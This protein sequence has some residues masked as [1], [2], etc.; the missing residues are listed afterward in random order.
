MTREVHLRMHMRLL[1]KLRRF[2]ATVTAVL[3]GTGALGAAAAV[4]ST[5]ALAAAGCSA[6]YSEPSVWNTGFTASFNV[7]NTG[8][9]AITGWT[10]V[11]TYGSGNPTIQPTGWN[12]T[13]SQTGNTVTITNMSYN[14]NLA[15]GA[16]ATGI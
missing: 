14:G 5:P 10:V 4:V 2:A 12:G 1:M 6:A 8:T 3:L 16:S 9:T 7:T 11:L 15:P 13:W